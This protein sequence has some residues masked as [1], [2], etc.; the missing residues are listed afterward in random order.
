M[1]SLAFCYSR[2]SKSYWGSGAHILYWRHIRD[3]TLSPS[4]DLR[5]RVRPVSLLWLKC[6]FRLMCWFSCTATKLPSKAFGEL[7][8]QT[9]VLISA[10]L[11]FWH[12]APARRA[13]IAKVHRCAIEVIR[14]FG[15]TAHQKVLVCVS[16]LLSVAIFPAPTPPSWT[17]SIKFY[18]E[19]ICPLSVEWYGIWKCNFSLWQ[20]LLLT[21]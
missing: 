6:W 7:A 19:R 13:P 1:V 20:C 21:H 3:V 5:A 4:Q 11:D 18:L 14:M 10:Y 17:P 9:T 15:W 12:S 8:L 2:K 16:F